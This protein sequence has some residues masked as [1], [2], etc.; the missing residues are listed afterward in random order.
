MA[1]PCVVDG[2]GGC[3]VAGP[4]IDIGGCAVGGGLVGAGVDAGAVSVHIHTFNG[5]EAHVVTAGGPVDKL[6]VIKT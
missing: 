2:F 5:I 1:G 3:V 6:I 4:G